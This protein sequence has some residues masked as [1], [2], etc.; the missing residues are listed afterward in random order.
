MLKAPIGCLKSSLHGMS[1]IS[2]VISSFLRRLSMIVLVPWSSIRVRGYWGFDYNR[3]LG[4]YI[5]EQQTRTELVSLMLGALRVADDGMR[6]WSAWTTS[7][8]SLGS[9]FSQDTN[10]SS[11]LSSE[12]PN[13]SLRGTSPIS[14]LDLE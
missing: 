10:G 8:Q 4:F 6:N 14:L 9:M 13:Y 2:L 3:L 11:C 12:A 5:F 7:S 1:I